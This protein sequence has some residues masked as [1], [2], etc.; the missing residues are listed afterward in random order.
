MSSGI[1]KGFPLN[2]SA[3]RPPTRPVLPFSR[4]LLVSCGICND[5]LLFSFLLS[6]SSAGCA[7]VSEFPRKLQGFG[8]SAGLPTAPCP[9][10]GK[11]FR[12]FHFEKKRKGSL[13]EPMTEEKPKKWGASA[14]M[15][16]HRHRYRPPTA[17][18]CGKMLRVCVK[19]FS[20]RK[21]NVGSDA[22]SR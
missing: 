12:L 6:W 14:D 2:R 4:L 15:M 20:V 21:A 11:R 13:C 5:V 19:F 3:G 18:P 8:V 9:K 17:R 22:V 1:V 7:N 10:K 16:P